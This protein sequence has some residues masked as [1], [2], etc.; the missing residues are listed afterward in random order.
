M[1]GRHG[2]GAVS[3]ISVDLRHHQPRQLWSRDAFKNCIFDLNAPDTKLSYRHLR[4]RPILV[5]YSLKLSIILS[6]PANFSSLRP[7][8]I[9][10]AGSAFQQSSFCQLEVFA[11]ANSLGLCRVQVRTNVSKSKRKMPPKK[12]VK[13]EKI[14]LGRPGN[15]LKS[16]IVR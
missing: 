13:E 12:A 9:K 4:R 6:L 16:G 7:S 10:A 5:A 15:N 1:H 8:V 11:R 2:R 14:L 3:G